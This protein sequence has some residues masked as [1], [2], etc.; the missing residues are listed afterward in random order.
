M[1]LQKAI[2]AKKVQLSPTL[3][4]LAPKEFSDPRIMAKTHDQIV[5]ETLVSNGEL[6]ADL[7]FV[8]AEKGFEPHTHHGHHLIFVISG[9]CTV[10]LGADIHRLLAGEVCLIPGHVAHA[11]TG[12]ADTM[13]LATGA[14]PHMRIDAEDRMDLVTYEVLSA[15][16]SSKIRCM[17][18]D[19]H[20]VFDREE[21]LG[22]DGIVRCPYMQSGQCCSTPC[23]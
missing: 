13:L 5:G 10:T 9:E 20:R 6:G 1:K 12:I 3:S 4:T 15:E 22:L 16:L 23:L 8:P 2:W 7:M 21:V 14:S 11:I 19:Q 18:C 17:G